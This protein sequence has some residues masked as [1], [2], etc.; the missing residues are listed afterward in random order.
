MSDRSIVQVFNKDQTHLYATIVALP[1][2]RLTPTDKTVL[3]FADW[4]AGSPE[5]IKAWFYP[6][7]NYGQEFVYPK[8]AFD[9]DTA[10]SGIDLA[11]AL[12][13]GIDVVDRSARTGVSPSAASVLSDC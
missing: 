9:A 1:D 12:H 6:G 8:S 11:K 3:T 2:Y 5:A 4:P 7:D 10:N 13:A